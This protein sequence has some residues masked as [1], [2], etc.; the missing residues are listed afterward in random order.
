MAGPS[1]SAGGGKKT[2]MWLKGTK[3]LLEK[4]VLTRCYLWYNNIKNAVC[5]FIL[6]KIASYL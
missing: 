6:K 5:G 2:A 4:I 1:D 3:N